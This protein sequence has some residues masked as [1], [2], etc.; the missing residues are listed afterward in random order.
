MIEPHHTKDR[1]L[2]RTESARRNYK[3]DKGAYVCPTHGSQTRG[4]SDCFFTVVAEGLDTY[5]S[6]V[7]SLNGPTTVHWM[8]VLYWEKAL[9]ENSRSQEKPRA[10]SRYES[11]WIGYKMIPCHVTPAKLLEYE[12]CS[13]AIL[14]VILKDEIGRQEGFADGTSLLTY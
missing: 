5:T 1:T 3:K 10:L 12:V 9:N 11:S 13:S 8:L 14:L 2:T 4:N 7:D 6:P